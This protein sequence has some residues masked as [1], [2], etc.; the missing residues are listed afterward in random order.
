MNCSATAFAKAGAVVMSITRYI[1][2]SILGIDACF[3]QSVVAVKPTD[4]FHTSYIYALMKTNVPTYMKLRT[5]A[6]QPHINKEI[7]EGTYMV[8]PR[9]EI[10]NKYYHKVEPLYDMQINAAQ[11]N[12]QLTSF[13]DFLLPMLMNGQ[14]KVR[15]GAAK[16]QRHRRR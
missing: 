5:G 11:E 9:S 6:Q 1:R 4:K 10:M 2:P 13:R 12:H 3:N 15:S 14:V 8:C 16:P 7:V